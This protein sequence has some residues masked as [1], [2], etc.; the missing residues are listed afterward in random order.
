MFPILIISG[1]I[2]LLLIGLYSVLKNKEASSITK[3]TFALLFASLLIWEVGIILRINNSEELLAIFD[4]IGYIGTCLSPVFLFIISRIFVHSK[5]KYTKRD[6][7]LFIIPILT[8]IMWYTN[9]YHNLFYTHYTK[10]SMTMGLYYYIHSAYTYG[11]LLIGLFSLLRYS[12]KNAGFF[13]RASIC[14]CLAIIIPVVLS[15]AITDLEIYFFIIPTSLAATALLLMLALFRFQ[16]LNITPI[17]MQKIVDR[18]SDG[19]IVLNGKNTI[20][21]FNETFLKMFHIDARTARNNNIFELI[22]NGKNIKLEN[23]ILK[24]TLEKAYTSNETFN[25][26]VKLKNEERYFNIE[27]NNIKS[28]NSFL[29]ILV[30]FKDITQHIKDMTEIERNQEIILNQE[31]FT[32]LGQLARRYSS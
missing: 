12:V 21:D 23:E 13:S 17:A 22:Q 24:E 28:K 6:W 14:I 18:M 9:D 7:L 2:L 4:G 29:G 32:T 30:L 20:T 5:Q 16:L 26:D 3:K 1:T 8:I 19:F 25:F 15:V 10:N 11:L 27:I 31:K